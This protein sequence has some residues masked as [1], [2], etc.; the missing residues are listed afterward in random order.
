MREFDANR[1]DIEG[2]FH[3]G[4]EACSRS[5]AERLRA[6]RREARFAGLAVPNF[7]RKP[8][9]PGWALVGDAGYNKDF[10]TAQGISD[11]FRDA[12]LCAEA[13]DAALSGRA[14]FDDAMGRYQAARDNASM[15]MYEFTAQFA[16]LE[17]PTPEMQQLMA[18]ISRNQESMTGFVRI[19]AGVVSPRDFFSPENV[20]RIF[21]AAG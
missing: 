5:F 18:A 2:H 11:A 17:P 13:L 6:G 1:S 19:F 14:T 3:R 16:A 10:M 9:G 4:L 20:G 7:F 8:F 21:A 15:P 12:E